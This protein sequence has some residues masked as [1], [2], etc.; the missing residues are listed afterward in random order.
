MPSSVIDH[1]G[2]ASD[3]GTKSRWLRLLAVF[4]RRRRRRQGGHGAVEDLGGLDE[5]AA[6]P[7]VEM[8]DE[9][10][11]EVFRHRRTLEDGG[12]ARD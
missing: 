1:A 10:E 12:T 8:R 5:V 3:A 7:T 4:R 9:G 11:G 6:S 2:P